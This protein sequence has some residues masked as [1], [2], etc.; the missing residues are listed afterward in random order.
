MQADRLH[1]PY[2]VREFASLAAVTVRALHHY[3]AVG[4]LRPKR[5]LAGYR[6]YTLADLERLEQVVALKFLGL[7]LKQIKILL[8]RGPLS[9]PD[10]L[11]VQLTTLEEKRRLLDHA[12]AAIRDAVNAVEAGKPVEVVV[13]KQIIGAINMQDNADFM[14]RY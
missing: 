3:E 5:T 12:I 1:K 9:L 11:Q 10:A 13:L 4:L 2:R 6:L 14:K 8:D 7:P